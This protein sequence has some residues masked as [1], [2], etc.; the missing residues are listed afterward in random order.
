M[1]T[2]IKNSVFTDGMISGLKRWQ[3][4]AKRKLAKRSNYL[5]AQN[6]L[7]NSLSLNISPSFKMMK[8]L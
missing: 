2:K 7:D 4:K 6:S 5:L 3:E 8:K 1:G